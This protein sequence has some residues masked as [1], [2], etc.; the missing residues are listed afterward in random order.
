MKTTQNLLTSEKFN[1]VVICTSGN[2]ELEWIIKL[3]Y[4]KCTVLASLTY[5]FEYR[6]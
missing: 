2:Y 3:Y 6:H 1:S 5:A 4:Y